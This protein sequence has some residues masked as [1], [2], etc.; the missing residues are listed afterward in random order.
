MLHDVS[1]QFTKYLHI[2]HHLLPMKMIVSKLFLICMCKDKKKMAEKINK[3]GGKNYNI[4]YID[5]M[6]L[7]KVPRRCHQRFFLLPLSALTSDPN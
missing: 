3:I 6:R 7:V 5:S 1:I 2:L 4:Q